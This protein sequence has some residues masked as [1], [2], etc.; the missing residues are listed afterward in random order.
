MLVCKINTNMEKIKK[1]DDLGDF[2]R[3]PSSILLNNSQGKNMPLWERL[4]AIQ[5]RYQSIKGKFMLWEEWQQSLHP[6]CLCKQEEDE[7]KK[8]EREREKI[9]QGG[10]N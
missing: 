5:K 9:R 7:G 6:L 2:R 8:E 1:T 4:A 10:G 3:R